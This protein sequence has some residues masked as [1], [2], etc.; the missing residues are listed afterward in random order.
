MA[1]VP[2]L[3]PFN[4]R[5]LL[6]NSWHELEHMTAISKD[7]RDCFLKQLQIPFDEVS[8]KNITVSFQ[9]CQSLEVSL[10][11]KDYAYELN[12][13]STNDIGDNQI[14]F[15]SKNDKVAPYDLLRHFRNCAAHKDRIKTEERTNCKYYTFTDIDKG[16]PTM[17][18]VISYK[19]WDKYILSLYRLILNNPIYECEQYQ[20]TSI[21]HK[22]DLNKILRK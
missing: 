10:V 3:F 13:L 22:I 5:L 1:I 16:Q 15:Y 18:A 7:E 9:D 12:G 19:I 2:T 14:I 11:R 8:K 6:G 21:T 17:L 20:K 4:N